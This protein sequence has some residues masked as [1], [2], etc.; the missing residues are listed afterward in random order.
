[1]PQIALDIFMDI[2]L[3]QKVLPGFDFFPVL[4]YLQVNETAGRRN[5][6]ENILGLQITLYFYF[7]FS[8]CYLFKYN[9]QSLLMLKRRGIC[10]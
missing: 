9:E 10:Q 2:A 5:A 4:V 3:M 6:W 8:F 7:Y 1:M